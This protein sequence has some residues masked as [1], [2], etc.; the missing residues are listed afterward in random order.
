MAERILLTDLRDG[1]TATIIEILGGRGIQNR[2][3]ALGMRQGV[4]V[5][6]ISGAFARGPA[7]LKVGQTQTAL[8]FGV[9]RKI[10]VEADR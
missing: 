3:Q 6:R 7:V 1:E 2:L 10:M 5:T 9:C 8:G 4:K